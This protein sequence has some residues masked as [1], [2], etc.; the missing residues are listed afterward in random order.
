MSDSTQTVRV[1]VPRFLAKRPTPQASRE[2]GERID[3]LDCLLNAYGDLVCPHCRVQWV[4]PPWLYVRPGYGR[5][6]GCH[7]IFRVTSAT[8]AE[9]NRRAEAADPRIRPVARARHA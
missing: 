8:A 5:C 4:T 9:A 6:S 2:A 3:A 7:G 1:S